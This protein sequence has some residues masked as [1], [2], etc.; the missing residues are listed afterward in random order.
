L[1][2]E[3]VPWP[4]GLYRWGLLV[5]FEL[6]FDCPT[7]VRLRFVNGKMEK[8]GIANFA[9]RRGFASIN[10]DAAEAALKAI[11]DVQTDVG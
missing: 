7:P 6:D 10:D 4:G 1:Q 3:G 11:H 2:R 9:L 8:T 5:P